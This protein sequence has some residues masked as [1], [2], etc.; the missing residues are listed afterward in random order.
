[1]NET[2]TNDRELLVWGA[3]VFGL[4]VSMTALVFGVIEGDVIAIAGAIGVAWSVF[5]LVGAFLRLD[6]GEVSAVVHTVAGVAVIVAVGLATGGWLVI[7]VIAVGWLVAC[8]MMW[9][10]DHPGAVE[11]RLR[12]VRVSRS[13]GAP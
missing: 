4:I 9:A 12:R 10:F 2:L 5:T 6:V 7:A 11:S 13:R 3:G 8:G 1:M